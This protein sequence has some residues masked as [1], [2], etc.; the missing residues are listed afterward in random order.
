MLGAIAELQVGGTSSSTGFERLA[1]D[2]SDVSPS[3]GA[4][5]AGFYVGRGVG[6]V[7]SATFDNGAT[8]ALTSDAC[9][10]ITLGAGAGAFGALSFAGGAAVAMDAPD[11]FIDIGRDLGSVGVMTVAGGSV[12]TLTADDPSDADVDVGASFAD[13]GRPIGGD[14]AL[15][16]SGAG[17]RA[18]C[19]TRRFSRR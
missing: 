4:G 15:L 9:A 11:A 1:V 19:S 16:V 13:F 17:S 3:A 2:A 12:V 8:L 10:Q 5:G 18:S 7:G 14:G 6:S